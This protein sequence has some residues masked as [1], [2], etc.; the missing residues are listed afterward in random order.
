MPWMPIAYHGRSS[1]IVTSGTPFKRPWGLFK[2]S[3]TEKPILGASRKLDYELELAFFVSKKTK[4]GERIPIAEARDGIFGCVLMNDWS[5][6]DIQ[7][8][9]IRPLVSNRITMRRGIPVV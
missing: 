8:L 3:P 9:E 6:R 7:G 1:S 5:A 4:L 2:P